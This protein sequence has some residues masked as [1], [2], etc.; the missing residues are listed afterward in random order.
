MAFSN[1]VPTIWSEKL[2]RT[3]DR[4]Y[5]AAAHCNREYE[6][7]IKEKGCKVRIIGID[8]VGIYNYTKNTDMAAPQQISD[9]MRDLTINQAKYFNF[10][11]DDVDR[12]QAVPG[13][14]DSLMHSAA[15]A[16]A[17]VAD[18]YIF[19]L[20][21]N[22]GYSIDVDSRNTEELIKAFLD[23]RTVLYRND[24][25]NSDDI[26]IEVS[27]EVAR[28]ILAGKMELQSDNNDTLENGCIGKLFGVKVFVSCNIAQEDT[29]ADPDDPDVVKSH[30]KCIMRTKRA[31]A[32]A[33]QLSEIEAY[34]PELRFADAVKGLHLY[35]AKVVYPDEMVTLDVSLYSLL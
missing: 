29:D 10:Q 7:E 6:G 30:H 5:I 13:I 2:W 19:S 11:V 34:R 28:L 25:N 23:A 14:M 18:Q 21:N 24:V 3:L 15:N 20:Y 33:S 22:A 12:A 4:K 9:S 31:I 1:F 17:D 8:N 27:P 26:V 35:G 32:Y 16:I